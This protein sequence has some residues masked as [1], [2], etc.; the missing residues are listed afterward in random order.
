MDT[1]E[2]IASLRSTFGLSQEELAARIGVARQTVVSWEQGA[3]PSAFNRRRIIEEFSLPINYFD[4]DVALELIPADRQSVGMSA[5]ELPRNVPS[6]A[7]S[8]VSS[9]AAA[10]GMPLSNHA[11]RAS[12]AFRS[13]GTV[14]RWGNV[15]FAGVIALGALFSIA[16]VLILVSGIAIA[17]AEGAVTIIALNGK[18]AL[19]IMAVFL[20][21]VIAFYS[22]C[23][24]VRLLLKEILR[25]HVRRKRDD[26]APFQQNKQK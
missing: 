6:E 18:A 15:F 23:F 2:K 14:I 20:G 22:V 26:E 11:Q 19:S 25:D 12:D 17:Q 8:E 16:A 7:S 5:S 21:F 10:E 9:E 13:L 1:S 4:A 24:F 3:R